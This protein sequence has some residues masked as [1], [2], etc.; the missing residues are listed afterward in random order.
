MRNE[1]HR[2]LVPSRIKYKVC[3]FA[4]NCLHKNALSYLDRM[5]IPVGNL[6]SRR[7]LRSA[8]RGD[9]VAP[10]AKTKTYG[11]CSFATAVPSA[12]K[13]LSPN[14]RDP[15]LTLSASH[16]YKNRTVFASV[17]H[18]IK[19]TTRDWYYEIRQRSTRTIIVIIII[20]IVIIIIIIQII[21]NNNKKK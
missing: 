2:P 10:R 5:W 8:F 3:R 20:I 17:S 13:L 6:D 1:L 18:N 15:S 21:K 19:V 16:I 7:H 11:P 12:W 4:F 9:L 14:T